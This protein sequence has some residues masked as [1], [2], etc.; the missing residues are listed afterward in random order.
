MQIQR[1]SEKFTTCEVRGGNECFLFSPRDMYFNKSCNYMS[2]LDLSSKDFYK[3]D[4]SLAS[5]SLLR[6][7][8]LIR[9]MGNTIITSRN[10]MHKKTP[11]LLLLFWKY[12]ENCVTIYE[13]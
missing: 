4:V 2:C 7:G 12:A 6:E 11:T 9:L 1:T 5:M 8:S 10:Q 3:S 13:V